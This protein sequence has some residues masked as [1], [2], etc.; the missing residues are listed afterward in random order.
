MLPTKPGWSWARLADV[1][2]RPAQLR[3]VLSSIVRRRRR[4]AEG[5]D[6][7]SEPLTRDQ[8]FE[9]VERLHRHHPP[10][11]GYRYAFAIVK[12]GIKIRGGK[13]TTVK[14]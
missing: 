11:A 2:R 8:A 4:G 9:I 7:T 12:D 13:A 5:G 14:R 6:V 10:A 1:W 3:D